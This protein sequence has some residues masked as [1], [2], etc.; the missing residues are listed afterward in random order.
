M[1]MRK[2]ILFPFFVLTTIA[3]QA[4]ITVDNTTMTPTQLVQN[5][6]VGSGVTVSNVAWNG[7][8]ADALIVQ[9]QSGTFSGT[10]TAGIGYGVILGSGDVTEAIGPNTSGSFTLGG[11][12]M[13][14]TDPDLQSIASAG[15]NDQAVLE[16]DFVPL[17]D[18]IKFRYVF[19]SEEYP[20]YVCSNF[21][22]VFG[23]FISGPNPAGGS[24]VAQNIAI[25]PGSG[26]LPVTINSVNPGVPGASSGGGTCTSLAYSMYYIN[27]LG[28]VT[29]QYDG[30]TTILTAEAAVI[31]NQTYHIKLAISDVGDFSFDS[32]VFLEA[33]SFSSNAV[34][35]TITTP[36]SAGFVNGAVYENCILGTDATFYMVR[37]NASDADTI[38]FSYTGSASLGAD[39]TSATPDTF[40]I[41]AVGQ[42]SAAFGVSILNDGV[43]EGL[44]SLVVTVYNILPCGDTFLT[45]GTL[46]INDPLIINTNI[47]NDTIPCIGQPVTFNGAFGGSPLDFTYTWTGP[48]GIGDTDT[49]VNYIPP[50]A[51]MVTFTATD[52]CGFTDSDTA[53][54]IVVPVPVNASG[55][56]DK[57]VPC[58][59]TIVNLSGSGSGGTGA[60]T[61]DW[62]GPSLS[63]STASTNY[64]VVSTTPVYFT[65]TDVCGQTDTDTV[66]VTITSVP[67]FANGGPDQTVPC[68]G[69]NV[70]L[71]GSGSSGT[72]AYSY[73]WDGPG[74][75]ATTASTLY[76]VSVTT[77]VYFT[78]TDACGQTDTDTVQVT[79]VPVPVFA[80]GGPDQSVECPGQLVTFNGSGSGGTGT[81]DYM[82][83]NTSGTLGTTAT[84]SY[85]P[86]ATEAVTLTVTDDCGQT[87][88]DVVMVTV[89]VVIPYSLVYT[90]TANAMCPGDPVNLSVQVNAGGVG[91]PWS[92]FWSNS[93]FD[94]N[95]TFNVTSSPMIVNVTVTDVCGNDTSVAYTLTLTTFPPLEITSTGGQLCHNQDLT[96]A[97]PVTVTGGAGGNNI[98]WTGPAMTITHDYTASAG[99]AFN[100]LSG[101][102]TVTVVDQCGNIASDTS[103]V[104][105]IPCDIT[106]PNIITSNGDGTNDVIRIENLEYHPNSSFVLFNRWGQVKYENGNYQNDYR[107]SDLTDGVYFYVLKLTDGHQ[108]SEYTGTIQVNNNK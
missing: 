25:I 81:I 91:S 27:N 33:G 65:V 24:Y 22:D 78:V 59:G 97:I 63:A 87:D 74:L 84:T 42:D 40:V 46:F 72:G 69:N 61:Y 86:T 19:A 76:N 30:L 1:R 102:Y 107:P 35:V 31:C 85:T 79:I 83:T 80:N 57:T 103:D 20:E 88:T 11:S 32:G 26:G 105:V 28:G 82:W 92:Y 67:V 95:T 9:P 55:G 99:V 53:M 43:P 14:G 8:M 108:P 50:A 98:G 60:Y 44:D 7:S 75:S 106:I 52:E 36:T 101:I 29:L 39:Y 4:Q 56:P 70:N 73:D 49:A 21:N 2:V 15:I 58:A 89:P 90:P 71:V 66:Q 23:F 5:V 16:F 34:E 6:L 77:P 93:D 96:I 10:S 94:N 12:G 48:G 100:P 13:S 62:D 54:I 37:P 68:A 47:V 38:S 51:G 104:T 3:A 45:S 64:S 17:G 41:F 18:S